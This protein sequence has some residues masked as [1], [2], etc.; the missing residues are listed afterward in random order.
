MKKTQSSKTN[1]LLIGIV[2]VLSIAPLFIAKDAA[3]GGADGE[4]EEAITEIATHYEPWF[5][6][7]ME[8]ASGEIES[9]LF[10]LQA[11]AG[12]G[13]LAYGFGYLKGLSKQIAKG[14]K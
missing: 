7:F 9:L 5:E 4:A 12:A 14:D 8:P 11:A 10:A 3:F 2:I 1:L 6:P 13:V